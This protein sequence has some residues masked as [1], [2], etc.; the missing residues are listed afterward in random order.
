M[1]EAGKWYLFN[2]L[3]H[4]SQTETGRQCLFIYMPRNI[5][6][7]ILFIFFLQRGEGREKERERNINVWLPLPCPILGTWPTT[8][9]CALTGN[10]NNYPLVHRSTL[11][12]LS[13]TSQGPRN[14]LNIILKALQITIRIKVMSNK[15]EKNY[16]GKV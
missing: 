15:T 14:M 6:F 16:K 12:P 2:N 8:Q 4:H 9:E 11:N 5:F 3:F 13:Y 1:E 7:K 10:R